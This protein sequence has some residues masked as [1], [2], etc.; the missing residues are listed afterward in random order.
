MQDQL[1]RLYERADRKNVNFTDGGSHC[2]QCIDRPAIS[3]HSRGCF[4]DGK[5]VAKL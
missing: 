4:K 3:Q 1:Q 2:E 5:C